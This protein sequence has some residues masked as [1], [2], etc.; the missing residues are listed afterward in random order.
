ML[1][2]RQAAEEAAHDAR[3]AR[4]LAEQREVEA[5]AAHARELEQIKRAEVRKAALAMAAQG[6]QCHC[7][8]ETLGNAHGHMT[9][10]H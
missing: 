6:W 7:S 4:Q 2:Y 1:C 10:K 5:K 8:V 3:C 9:M